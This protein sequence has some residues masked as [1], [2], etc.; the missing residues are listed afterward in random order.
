[1]MTSETGEDMSMQITVDD[2]DGNDTDTSGLSQLAFNE[3]AT[4]LT[5]VQAGQSAEITIDGLR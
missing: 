3:N 2:D 5:Q 1:M 4:N